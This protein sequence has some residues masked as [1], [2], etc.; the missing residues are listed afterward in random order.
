MRAQSVL[1]T[2]ALL[3]LFMT[4]ILIAVVNT[5]NSITR[6]YEKLVENQTASKVCAILRDVI[7][8]FERAMN[9]ELGNFTRLKEE[10]V[11][12]VELLFPEKV[13]EKSYTITLL[14]STVL[15]A[16]HGGEERTCK[17][18]TN[19]QM[20]GRCSG[21]CKL[22]FYKNSTSGRIVLTHG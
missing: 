5:T 7:Y 6:K 19:L 2:H 12:E 15:F 21:Y 13:G 10:K 18:R 4:L 22:V 8:S 17:V 16:V 3:V 14:N 20:S 9:S 11:G 1:T